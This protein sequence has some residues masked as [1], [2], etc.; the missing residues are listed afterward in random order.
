MLDC[1]LAKLADGHQYS[2]PDDC[3]VVEVVD[4]R[5]DHRVSEKID[6]RQLHKP[7]RSNDHLRITD[8][9]SVPNATDG[10]PKTKGS[11]EP[12]GRLIVRLFDRYLNSAFFLA[13]E[14]EGEPHG[15]QRVQPAQVADI[16]CN[17]AIGS[18]IEPHGTAVFSC[19]CPSCES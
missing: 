1:V 14:P 9:E 17:L 5:L 8:G 10:F 2:V 15:K 16:Q 4:E 7:G 13:I 3:G 19:P 18:G 11:K 6:I 12:S